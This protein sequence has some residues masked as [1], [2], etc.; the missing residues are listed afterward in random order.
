MIWAE[1]EVYLQAGGVLTWRWCRWDNLVHIVALPGLHEAM[2]PVVEVYTFT[3]KG[4]AVFGWTSVG[5]VVK[6]SFSWWN[7][8]MSIGVRTET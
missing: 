4:S 6:A 1:G 8:E 7:A 5:V 2:T 3:T